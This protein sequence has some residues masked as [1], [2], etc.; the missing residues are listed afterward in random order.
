M[1]FVPTFI[2]PLLRPIAIV[3]LLLVAQRTAAQ[4]TNLLSPSKQAEVAHYLEQVQQHRAANNFAQASHY[5]NKAAFAHWEVGD[6]AMALKH[7]GETAELKERIGDYVGLKAVY[8]NMALI[9]SD[10]GQY[11]MAQDCFQKS[12][13][14]RR[15][16]GHQADIAAGLVDVAYISIAQ[17]QY[18]KALRNLDE[19]YKL[20]QSEKHSRLNSHLPEAL[21]TVLRAHGQH[22]QGQ[23][24][25]EHDWHVRTA[26]LHPA[27][28]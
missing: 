26:A 8:S 21:R 24:V 12:L 2:A 10:I 19:G 6:H 1:R 23:R 14:A 3:V 5:L 9:Y 4:E 27:A 13:N 15:K 25:P 18:D 28:T 17:K 20:A 22:H 11:D 16:T 7:F